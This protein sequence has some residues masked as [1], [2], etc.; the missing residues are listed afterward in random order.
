M[1]PASQ[2]R[3][4]SLMTRACRA[5]GARRRPGR[6]ARMRR[7]AEE[8]SWRQAAGERPAMLATSANE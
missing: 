8:A 5:A 2:A 7:R 4:N 3:L 1:S 6:A